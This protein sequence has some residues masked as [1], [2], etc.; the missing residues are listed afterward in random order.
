M[1]E[2]KNINKKAGSSEVEKNNTKIILFHTSLQT[3][4]YIFGFFC[5]CNCIKFGFLCS[6]R[7]STKAV[8][9]PTKRYDLKSIWYCIK[10]SMISL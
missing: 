2:L 9:K 8:E 10:K 6:Q 7:N 3:L 1:S 4:F 5:A